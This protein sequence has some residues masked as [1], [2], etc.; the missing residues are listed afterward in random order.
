LKASEQNQIPRA[1]KFLATNFSDVEIGYTVVCETA[2]AKPSSAGPQPKAR[3]DP[4]PSSLLCGIDAAAAPSQRSDI[5]KATNYSAT[6]FCFLKRYQL[7][8]KFQSTAP[9]QKEIRPRPSSRYCAH[10]TAF[11]AAK[12]REMEKEN[13]FA[14]ASINQISRVSPKIS[15]RW[16]CTAGQLLKVRLSNAQ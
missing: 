1:R 2:C 16:G 13:D 10:L 14:T 11:P 3:R 4:P 7:G 12:G 9:D 5:S 6:F 8:L 15:H